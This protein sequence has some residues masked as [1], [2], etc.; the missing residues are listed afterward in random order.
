MSSSSDVNEICDVMPD[1][2]DDVI[3]D[4]DAIFNIIDEDGDG[5]ISRTELVLHLVKAGY[6]EDSVHMLF[7]KLDANK[8]EVLSRN[9]LRDGFLKFTPLRSA[10]G[11]GNYN[12][13]F[14]DEIHADADALFASID[15]DASGTIT[16][17]ELRNHLKQ[18]SKYSFKAIS[19]IFSMLDVNRDGEIEKQELR[20]AFVKYSALRQ[21]IGEGPNFK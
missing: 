14:V 13:Q 20:D 11:L 19:N 2:C 16:K 1:V 17:D 6:T 7:E 8:D 15:V 9:E 21:A 4:A 18:F 5:T 3:A 10:P 12:E